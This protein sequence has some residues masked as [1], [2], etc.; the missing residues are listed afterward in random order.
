VLPGK[1]IKK[2]VIVGIK[3]LARTE[4]PAL[5]PYVSMIMGKKSVTVDV[6]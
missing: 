4:S 1:L 3:P 6:T 5:A 2:A